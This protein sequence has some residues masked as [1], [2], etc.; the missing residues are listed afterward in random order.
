M[1]PSSPDEALHFRGKTLTPE[2]PRPLHLP[3]P[4]NIPVLQNQMDPVFNDTSTYERTVDFQPPQVR[5]GWFGEGGRGQG[6][7]H[8]SGSLRGSQPGNP[9]MNDMPVST[10]FYHSYPSTVQSGH[11]NVNPNAHTQTHAPPVVPAQGFATTSEI[12]S[13]ANTGA[14]SRL[15]EHLD[16]GK[17]HAD[18][19]VAGVNLQ[20]LLDNLSH[21]PPSNVA[22]GAPLPEDSSLHQ[23]PKDGPHHIQGGSMQPLPEP[24]AQTIYISNDD[25]TYH[26]PSA[27][28]T[29]PTHPTQPSNNAQSYSQ[30]M[31][32]GGAPGTVPAGSFPPPPASFPTPTSGGGS[33]T[34]QEASQA[35]R[36]T[37]IDKQT[38]RLIKGTDDDDAPWGPEVQKKYDEFLHDERVYVTEGLW[39]RFPMGS[40]LFVGESFPNKGVEPFINLVFLG[41][42]PTERVTKRDMFHIFHKYGKLAQIS[43][44]QAYGFI[45]FLEAG[46]CHAALEVEQ[47]ALIRGRK[48]HLEISK[49]QRNSRP[50]PAE[51]S[52]A[53]P[54]RRSRSPEFSR[55]GPARSNPRAPADRYDRPYEPS[56][57]PFSDYRDEPSN[58]RRDG[59]R[60]PRSPSPRPRPRDGYRS[61]DRTPER[62]DRRERRRS[63]SPRSRSRSPYSRDRRYRS[64]SPRPRGTYEG[65]AD[66]PVPRRAPRDVPEVQ[67][68]VLEEID[69]NFVLHV[70]NA[71]RNRGLRVDVLVLGPRIPLGAAVHRQYVEGVL[72]VIRL[73]RPNQFSRKIPLQIFDRSPG[74]NNVRFS[75]YPE[76]DPNIAAEVMFHQAQAMQRGPPPGSFPP[77]PA[78]GV[79]PIPIPAMPLPQ[80]TLPA[81]T[82]APNIANLISSL[83]G[84]SLQSLLSALQRPAAQSQPV[85][86]TQSPFSSP[87]PPPPADLA[88]LLT[89]AARPPPTLQHAPQPL[90]PPFH[91]QPPNGPVVSD[92]HL[93]SLLAKGLGAQQPQGQPAVGSNV[94]NLMNHLA[95]WK[96]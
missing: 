74:Q 82:N 49:P 21:L 63:R 30:S 19:S 22:S 11:M 1:T 46:S 59:Y 65:E 80:A 60:P 20:N 25:G 54:P 62:F 12:D 88:A 61:R 17:H 64:P 73:S 95:K 47:G 42:L 43:I 4:S 94:Q 96:Q 26:H 86:A 67:V 41:N 14:A 53:P 13:S 57:I 45:Q 68:L 91:L 16:N 75:D 7:T 56:R 84:P 36:K 77:N 89:N 83:D 15:P 34:S 58:R 79:A 50:A 5:D 35:S 8:D 24:P 85:S 69:R 72:A 6:H 38:G 39:D 3:E 2:S 9:V 71:F 48:I 40:R 55:A 90:P 27:L 51:P 18:S 70:E 93:L 37:R 44:K 29:P 52:R 33:Q 31:A 92:P 76:V 32:L 28:A 66:L 10:D 78:F 23:A 81:L 87:N